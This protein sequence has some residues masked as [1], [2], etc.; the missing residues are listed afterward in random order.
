MKE[1]YTWITVFNKIAFK[2]MEFKNNRTKML[3]IM[4]EILEEID[5][6]NEQDE[7][8][9]NLDKYNGVR[10]KYDDFDPFSFMNRLAI[11]STENKKKFIK[12]FEEKTGMNIDV[13][14]DFDGI[15]SVSPRKSCMIAF[16]DD[17]EE[18]DIPD[19]WRLFEIALK[20]PFDSSLKDDFIHYYDICVGKPYCNYDVSSCLYRLNGSYYFSFDSTNRNFLR[21]EFNIDIK[22]CPTGSEYL[23]LLNKIKYKIINSSKFDSIADF[24]HK[25]WLS[26]QNKEIFKKKIWLYSPGENAAYWNDCISQ[27]KIVIGW[28]LLGDLS[29]NHD[30][31]FI[32]SQ[33]KELYGG[34]N[35]IMSKCAIDDFTNNMRV[36]DIVIAK[37]G[38]RKLLGYG[39]ITSDYYFDNERARF[40]HC[41]NIDWKKIGEWENTSGTKNA[42]KTLT[43]IS[44]YPG[45]P[46][47]LLSIINGDNMNED[48]NYYWLNANPKFWSFSNIN[49]GET[50]EFT[51]I[52]SNGNKRSVYRNFQSIKKGDRAIAYEST[53]VK[54]IVGICEVVEG[55]N[56]D[57]NV[58]FKKID[59]FDNPKPYSEIKDLP[60]LQ[61]M[62]YLRIHQGSLFKLTKEEYDFISDMMA[63]DNPIVINQY[64]EYTS[65]DFLDEVYISTDNY[66]EIVNL[67]NK[68][69]N[70]ILQGPPGIGKTFM[71]ERLV[72]SIM[73]EKNTDR[74][75][76]I[77][78]HQSYS[79][80]DF[81][82]GIRI[83]GEGKFDL[84]PGIF[85]NFCQKA[86]KDP[87]NNYYLIID[88]INRGNLSKIFGEL[89]MLIEND[90]RGKKLTLAYSKE[91]FYVPK[92]LYII[93]MMNT[94][95][96]SLAIL[97]YALRRRFS[98]VDILPA[99]DNELF[100]NYQIEVNNTYLNK[101]IEN[102]KE[103]NKEI[104]DDPSL[105][106]GFMIGHSYFCG[107]NEKCKDYEVKS[108]IKYDILPMLKEYW[109]DDESKFEKWSNK[110]LGE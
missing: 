47:K 25:A 80:E 16:K 2:L 69:L 52:N 107:L 104:S 82:E 99:F 98:F 89:L 33:L 78:F 79:Y 11:Y 102:I 101:T 64:D 65:K 22:N 57:G 15:P 28:D 110:L 17:R 51:S 14:N 75:K 50:I 72:Y 55:L 5:Q 90:K 1:K 26:T 86:R 38:Q 20:Y 53:P 103:L 93:G 60:E 46:E 105:G 7:T 48:T 85:Y 108:I 18:N 106:K 4:Y 36:G 9:C 19:F 95:D 8:N 6:F 84:V 71:A 40:K 58:I 83:N 96:R 66:E 23:E 67:L 27:N 92:N 31:D 45:Y 10:C 70:I 3:D 94:A 35:P 37:K 43:E 62:E 91:E 59:E 30:P 76:F 97:D 81:I 61:N 41:R 74:V 68:K 24:S 88:E 32:M 109:F 100:K 13:P 54:K 77:Q 21:K 73:G 12:S 44:Q 29:S 56:S 87:E 42:I 34:D 63:E 49:I 39:E